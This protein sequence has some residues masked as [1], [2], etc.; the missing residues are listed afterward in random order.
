M[1]WGGRRAMI[2]TAVMSIVG[3][4]ISLISSQT[5]AATVTIK[6]AKVLPLSGFTSPGQITPGSATQLYIRCAPQASPPGGAWPPEPVQSVTFS[7]ASTLNLATRNSTTGVVTP[8]TCAL[9][10]DGTTSLTGSLQITPQSG[11]AAAQVAVLGGTTQNQLVMRTMVIKN[12]TP[13]RLQIEL[14]A[15]HVFTLAAPYDVFKPRYYGMGFNASFSRNGGLALAAGDSIV[16]RGTYAYRNTTTNL[17]VE[18]EI[19]GT[20]TPTDPG[21]VLTYNVPLSGSTIANTIPSPAQQGTESSSRVCSNV[22]LA[23]DTCSQFEERLRTIITVV[24]SPNDSVTIPNGDHGIAGGDFN[25][26][27]ETPTGGADLVQTTLDLLSA[28]TR[29]L[30]NTPV[31]KINPDDQGTLQLILFGNENFDVQNIDVGSLEFGPDGAGVIAFE[32]R[33]TNG[34]SWKKDGELDLA[35]KINMPETGIAPCDTTATLTGTYFAQ[36]IETL[37]LQA[38]LSP[39]EATALATLE[40]HS[41]VGFASVVPGSPAC[42][43]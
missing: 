19:G 3:L 4:S 9:S 1:K 11:A 24:L 10:E 2:L 26:D 29:I 27:S 20:S 18:D 40:F 34:P 12:T 35:L 38:G 23:P 21:T 14:N 17:F 16:K 13:R 8:Q 25:P 33:D 41:T 6:A 32:I 31:V 43:P 42:A 28:Q 5:E 30:Q 22:V 39:A 7:A 15:F 36:N 37:A